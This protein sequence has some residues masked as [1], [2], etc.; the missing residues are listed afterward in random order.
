MAVWC[1][2]ILPKLLL[3]SAQRITVPVDQTPSFPRE[4]TV[5]RH[6]NQ[7]KPAD[8]GSGGSA[9]GDGQD[10]NKHGSESIPPQSGDG[11]DPIR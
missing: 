2:R 1:V 5:G 3:V 8:S 9:G 6:G 7:D 10:P 11:Q 4:D